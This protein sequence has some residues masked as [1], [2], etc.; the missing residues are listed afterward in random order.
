VQVVNPGEFM[1]RFDRVHRRRRGLG[2][3]CVPITLAPPTWIFVLAGT[4]RRRVPVYTRTWLAYAIGRRP[5][6][7]RGW[8]WFPPAPFLHPGGYGPLYTR[9][10]V[11]ALIDTAQACGVGRAHR[12]NAIGWLRF[13][14]GVLVRWRALGPL[15]IGKG[16]RRVPIP[17]KAV[18]HEQRDDSARA[19]V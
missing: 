11:E 17:G 18:T 8:D 5:R 12:A 13:K 16:W 3:W 7:V 6:T 10:Q 2:R 1:T 14:A 19:V 4:P 15:G 9:D